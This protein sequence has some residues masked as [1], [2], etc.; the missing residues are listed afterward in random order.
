M[1]ILLLSTTL[2]EILVWEWAVK[3]NKNSKK[4]KNVFISYVYKLT[5][6]I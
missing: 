4:G 3:Q 2:P 1:G 5:V 6:T